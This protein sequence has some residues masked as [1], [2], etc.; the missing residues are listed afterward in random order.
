[1]KGW[2]NSYV[3]H[4]PITIHVPHWHITIQA[5]SRAACEALAAQL[6]RDAL[7]G[8]G[9][10][11]EVADDRGL[12]CRWKNGRKANTTKDEWKPDHGMGF[13]NDGG[14]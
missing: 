10:R 4:W 2:S 1:M 14:V 11:V 9:T 5:P 6:S 8:V 12:A 13:V 3:P 7:D